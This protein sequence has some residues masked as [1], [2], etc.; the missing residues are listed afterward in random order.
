MLYHDPDV[1]ISFCGC[2][3]SWDYWRGCGIYFTCPT[4]ASYVRNLQQY[5]PP[6]LRHKFPSKL[7]YLLQ[8]WSMPILVLI[9]LLEPPKWKI[10]PPAKNISAYMDFP[11]SF[12]SGSRYRF[13]NNVSD[14]GVFI[15]YIKCTFL[16]CPPKKLIYTVNNGEISHNGNG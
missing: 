6:H 3:F 12:T 5:Y 14:Q 9:I 8:P 16:P 11:E 13:Y 4:L 7:K 10:L 2:D 1:Y 15:L